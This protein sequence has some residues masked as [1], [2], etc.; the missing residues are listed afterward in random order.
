MRFFGTS[1]SHLGQ[2]KLC[3]Q[4][5][6][7]GLRQIKRV[8]WPATSSLSR[9]QSFTPEWATSPPATKRKDRHKPGRPPDLIQARYHQCLCDNRSPARPYRRGGKLD[10]YM[11]S[12]GLSRMV[13]MFYSTRAYN[14]VPVN[15]RAR[16]LLAGCGCSS[17]AASC[18]YYRAV[19][20]SNGRWLSMSVLWCGNPRARYVH[21]RHDRLHGNDAITFDAGMR[22]KRYRVDN[23]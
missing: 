6:A 3:Y 19:L 12:R 22:C 15:G 9:N 14:G 8:A 1:K 18:E 16:F 21:Q 2:G 13:R 10:C 23:I 17:S 4:H 5:L 11:L 7:Q 20:E